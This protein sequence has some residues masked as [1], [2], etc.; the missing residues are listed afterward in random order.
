MAMAVIGSFVAFAQADYDNM[1]GKFGA[2]RTLH[3]IN[4]SF[5]DHIAF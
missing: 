3:G 2:V 5:D 4:P 1:S